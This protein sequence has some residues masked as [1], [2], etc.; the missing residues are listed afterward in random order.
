MFIHVQQLINPIRTFI[1]ISIYVYGMQESS[2]VVQTKSDVIYPGLLLKVTHRSK[3][4][5]LNVFSHFTHS[6]GSK[7][8]CGSDFSD[9]KPQGGEV[10]VRKENWCLGWLKVR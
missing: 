7:V 5:L 1:S 6:S 2:Q 4:F 3:S 8:R 10:W 9:S